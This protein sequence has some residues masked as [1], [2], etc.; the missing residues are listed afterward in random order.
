MWVTA[1]PRVASLV[2]TPS[3]T[4]DTGALPVT[5]RVSGRDSLGQSVQ[6]FTG[7]T[8]WAVLGTST[9]PVALWPSVS[10]APRS[11]SIDAIVTFPTAST[12][13][14]AKIKFSTRH[15]NAT[16]TVTVPPVP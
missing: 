12:A 3:D 4:V 8:T 15:A 1:V 6:V 7:R 5:V 9:I 14:T 10:L 16:L 13:G 11:T 2:I